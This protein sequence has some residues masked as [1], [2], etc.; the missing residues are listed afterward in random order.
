[1]MSQNLSPQGYN[2]LAPPVNTNP[3]WGD[4]IAPPPLP[5]APVFPGDEGQFYT[6]GHGLKVN[7]NIVSVETV[8]T[9]TSGDQT[10]PMTA[11]GVNTIV[12]NIEVLLEGI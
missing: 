7:N 9:T 8:S 10:L 3:F 4:G 6:F 11:A 2:I 12:G 5:G 1:M